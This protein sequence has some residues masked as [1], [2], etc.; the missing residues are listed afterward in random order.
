M[1]VAYPMNRGERQAVASYLGTVSRRSAFRRAPTAA[2]RRATVSR[3]A[4][5]FLEPLEPNRQQRTIP[6]RGG[7]RAGRRRGATAESSSGRSGLTATS[8]PSPS[9]R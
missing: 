2:A 8:P 5:V 6:R 9:R 3:H 4:D 7:R 1:T